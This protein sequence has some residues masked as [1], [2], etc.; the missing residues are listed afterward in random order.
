MEERIARIINS[1]SSLDE[2]AQFETN[3]RDRNALTDEIKIAIKA[4]TVEFGRR[5]VSE[6]AGLNLIH[7]S[8]AEQKIVDTVGEFV[9]LRRR[10][11][12]P[13]TRTFDQLRNHGLIG[14]AESAV[15][16]SNLPRASRPSSMLI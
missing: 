14:A 5:L 13:T 6:K 15:S 12:K 11:G 9:A 7:L 4:K 8:P 3:V 16:R 2:L 1:I 10:Q